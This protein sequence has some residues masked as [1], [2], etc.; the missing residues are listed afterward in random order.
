MAAKTSWSTL[1]TFLNDTKTPPIPLLIAV[2]QIFTDFLVKA[3]LFNNVFSQQGTAIV[4]NSSIL[5]NPIFKT[6][7]S[8]SRFKFSKTIVF[9][10]I[11]AL[12]PNKAFWA[13]WNIYIHD[14]NMCLFNCKTTTY[15]LGNKCFS[16]KENIVY[17]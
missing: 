4:N 6:E 1:K 13:W 2:N 17:L 10:V 12:N 5:I 14:K 16:K 15:Y 9:K 8:L 11:K 3:N 7:D